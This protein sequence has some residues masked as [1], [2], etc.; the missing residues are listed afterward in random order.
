MTFIQASEPII[1]KVI[2]QPTGPTGLTDVLIGALGLTGA[3]VLLAA[4]AGFLVAGLLFW[5]R[6]KMP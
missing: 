1:V 2:E 4:V 5:F 3:L 6:S